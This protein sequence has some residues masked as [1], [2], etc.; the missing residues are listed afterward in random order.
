MRK[1]IFLMASL[2]FMSAV[3]FSQAKTVKTV[4]GKFS[5]SEFLDLG[6]KGFLTVVRPKFTNYPN[7]VYFTKDLEVLYYYEPEIY[8]GGRNFITNYNEDH[9][10]GDYIYVRDRSGM[11][12]KSEKINFIQFTT[13]GKQKS[14]EFKETYL[15]GPCKSMFCTDK[16]L[17]AFHIFHN[18]KEKKVD[19]SLHRFDHETF[20]YKAIPLELPV[21]EGDIE[22][23]YS[24]FSGDEI[25]LITKTG[26]KKELSYTV[27]TV[28]EEGKVLREI[29][30]KPDLSG[31][32]AMPSENHKIG[33]VYGFIDVYDHTKKRGDV[34]QYT[35]TRGRGFVT[36]H[37]YSSRGDITISKKNNA[38]YLYGF[39]SDYNVFLQKYDLSGALTW[40]L[41]F[42]PHY[43]YRKDT[44]NAIYF[45][46]AEDNSINFHGHQEAFSFTQDG[47]LLKKGIYDDWTQNGGLVA[48]FW[49]M[50]CDNN[51]Y[52]GLKKFY[53]SSNYKM[54]A[55][56]LVLEQTDN[57]KFITGGYN[58][59][60]EIE[61]TTF[62]KK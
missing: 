40:K 3:S 1:I 61:I 21:V 50:H 39:D 10:Y 5:F 49:K 13:K 53:N 27:V 59:P 23:V 28:N 19:Y 52:T 25:Y 47:V 6:D 55:N 60:Q 4:K 37:N 44:Y 22:Y 18:K 20:T 62:K 41:L 12:K 15:W 29:N 11:R 9:I 24:N 58:K 8:I 26:K 2:A 16:Y 17:F 32:E 45:E 43:K 7:L 57:L 56:R 33:N 38:I 14:K 48:H 34:T 46:I 42:A 36:R 54:K 30:I 35:E 51:E 31:K